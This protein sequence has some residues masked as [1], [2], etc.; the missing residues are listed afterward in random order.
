MYRLML[1]AVICLV[2]FT[3]RARTIQKSL[4][5]NGGPVPMPQRRDTQKLLNPLWWS[6][7]WQYC[8]VAPRSKRPG[9]RCHR[10]AG[11][12]LRTIGLK[13]WNVATPIC[14]QSR[15]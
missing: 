12:T 13:R 14:L 9:K 10:K 6:H 3:A 5:K 7:A 2:S 1:A 8:P 11:H 15:S 4:L